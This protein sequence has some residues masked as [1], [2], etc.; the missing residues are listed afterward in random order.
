MDHIVRY[1]IM[2]NSS[3]NFIIYCFIGSNFRKTFLGFIKP[4]LNR[5]RFPKTDFEMTMSTIFKTD[6]SEA[7]Q[8]FVTFKHSMKSENHNMTSTSKLISINS[9]NND[10]DISRVS[11]VND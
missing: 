7:T 4:V 5:S 9:L 10:E 3:I 8:D 1:L 2:L 6:K 11:D